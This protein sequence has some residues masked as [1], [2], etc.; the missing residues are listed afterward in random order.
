[1][2]NAYKY[3][4]TS[5]H[6][7]FLARAILYANDGDRYLSELMAMLAQMLDG[8]GSIDAHYVTIAANFGFADTTVA[9]NAYNEL[10]SFYAK[11]SGN[12]SVSSVRAARDQAC[13]R[14]AA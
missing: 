12:G 13:A 3:S 8:D 6:G 9:H 5:T 14:F 10:N 11:T 2:S 7:K 1:M 4:T